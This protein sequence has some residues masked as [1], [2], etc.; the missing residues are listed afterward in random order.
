MKGTFIVLFLFAALAMARVEADAEGA[1]AAGL[2]SEEDV[3]KLRSEAIAALEKPLEKMKV[4]ELKALLQDRGVVCNACAEKDQLLK[5][6]RESMHLPIKKDHL[7]KINMPHQAD[8][9]EIQRIMKELK[10]K[11]EQENKLKDMLKAQ[12][13]ATDGISFGGGMN[14]DEMDKIIENMQKKK[15]DKAEKDL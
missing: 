5:T 8:D 10:S 2:R 7:K 3:E 15:D 1:P 14:P 9:D 4:K 12:G 6:V 11:Q 13:I